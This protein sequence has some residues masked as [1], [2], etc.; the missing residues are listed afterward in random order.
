MAVGIS[1]WARCGDALLQSHRIGWLHQRPVA[2]RAARRCFDA[3][4]SLWIS[5]MMESMVEME[6]REHPGTTPL[7]G[8]ASQMSGYLNP[9]ISIRARI[10]ATDLRR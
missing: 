7:Y 9:M 6:Q 10:G 8:T 2:I 1:A 3:K 4:V 5:F